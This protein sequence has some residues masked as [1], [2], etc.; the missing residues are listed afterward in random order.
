[1]GKEGVLNEVVTIQ[2]RL[3]QAGV[4]TPDCNNS[5]ARGEGIKYFVISEIR[6]M[7]YWDA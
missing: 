3:S 1:M 5:E 7:R 2:R 6:M 4:S